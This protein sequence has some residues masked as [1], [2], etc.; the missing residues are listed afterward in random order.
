MVMPQS[1]THLR[2]VFRNVY[3]IDLRCHGNGVVAVRD[4][5]YSVLDTS[6]VVEIL[7][8]IAGLK[9]CK[10]NHVSYE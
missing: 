8:P 7:T 5:A 9:V 10:H 1:P 6:K 2:I 4:G 3:C